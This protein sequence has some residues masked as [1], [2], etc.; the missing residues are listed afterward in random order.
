MKK[1]VNTRGERAQRG[2]P[3]RRGRV[4]AIVAVAVAACAVGG[5][6]LSRALPGNPALQADSSAATANASSA[7]ASSAAPAFGNVRVAG[8]ALQGMDMEEAK[9]AVQA[10]L[11]EQ[12]AARLYTLQGG[13]KTFQLK[14][15]SLKLTYDI[16]ALLQQAW[17]GNGA[18][19]AAS[20][21]VA[22][23]A[24]T[25]AAPSA[26]ATAAGMG[27]D[28]P[29]PA[30]SIDE[31]ALKQT[32]ADLV[33][34]LNVAAKE[35]TVKSVQGYNFTFSEGK[36][37]Q[38]VE[39][40]KLLTDVKAAILAGPSATVQIQIKTV[41]C[42]HK[43]ADV[44]KNFQ[45][46]GSFTTRSVNN[47]N[48]TYN[49]SKAL[50]TVN[51][52][53]VPA[54]GIFSFLGVVGSADKASGYKEAG[55]IVNGKSAV[56]YGGG[57]CQASTTIYGAAVRSNVKIVQRSPHSIPSKYVPLGQDAAVSYPSQ[58]MKFQNTTEYPMYIESGANGRTMYCNIYGYKDPSWDK[59]EVTS[60]QTAV[61]KKTGY[62]NGYRA[63]AQRIFYKNGKVVRREAL[64]SS[65][66]PPRRIE[67]AS[68]TTTSTKPTSKAPASSKKASKPQA[69]SKKPPTSSAQAPD[70][71]NGASSA[72]STKQNP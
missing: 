15:S 33:K 58:N 41:P 51:G 29:A 69:S 5:F 44:Q 71:Q 46:L 12:D 53:V 49:M 38:A 19:S 16:D 42:K 56:G 60:Q 17:N 67:G 36:S 1:N 37:G 31:A 34:P 63:T 40:E 14:G 62:K 39:Q 26:S 59:I 24:A 57:I 61:I 54:G 23:L 70:K 2:T 66:Y 21:V 28:I 8:V 52:T 68:T 25:T 30:P 22:D 7:L 64:P 27:A 11:Q 55:V 45:K 13:G 43:A 18:A 3:R 9:A 20:A 32:L 65:Y 35:P 47:A 6:A 72:A 50:R 4:I 10:R 48:G